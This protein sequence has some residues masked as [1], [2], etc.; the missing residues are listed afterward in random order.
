MFRAQ[1]G[2]Y[3]SQFYSNGP[4]LHKKEDENGV[5]YKAAFFAGSAHAG[6]VERIRVFDDII[7]KMQSNEQAFYDDMDVGNI[8]AFNKKYMLGQKLIEY[9]KARPGGIPASEIDGNFYQK[10]QYFIL[11]PLANILNIKL[12]EAQYREIIEDIFKKHPEFH[13]KILTMVL[14]EFNSTLSIREVQEK[15]K[16]A[17]WLVMQANF[18]SSRT[19]NKYF[20]YTGDFKAMEGTERLVRRVM[21]KNLENNRINPIIA[22]ELN[23]YYIKEFLKPDIGK[24]VADAKK[25][26]NEEIPK[27]IASSGIGKTENSRKKQ[28]NFYIKLLTATIDDWANNIEYQKLFKNTGVMTGAIGEFSFSVSLFMN[29]DQKFIIQNNNV[30]KKKIKLIT[31]SNVGEKRG[32]SPKASYNH[33][34]GLKEGK[35]RTPGQ[36]TQDIMFIGKS[37]RKYAFSVKNYLSVILEKAGGAVQIRGGKKIDTFM[38]DI[39]QSGTADS[40]SNI[41]I[42]EDEIKRFAYVLVNNLFRDESNDDLLNLFMGELINF[43][44]QNEFIKNL[45]HSS[46][47]IL[48]TY[49]DIRNSFLVMSGMYLIPMSVILTNI[50]DN[51][52]IALNKDYT[53]SKNNS[54]FNIPKFDLE[55]IVLPNADKLDTDK[56]NIQNANEYYDNGR[57]T[58][59]GAPQYGDE[60]LAYGIKAGDSIYD[61]LSMPDMEFRIDRLLGIIEAAMR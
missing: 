7:T 24:R 21:L 10:I 49:G 16:D 34:T 53:T 61:K 46:A 48:K 19:K 32:T 13:K 14:Q 1:L 29:P 17:L 12:E 51:L 41:S 59:P 20:R 33:K 8:T 58:W 44:L 35:D 9:A 11:V 60:M 23:N 22:E 57:Y 42:T 56:K 55:G 43:Y 40:I 6:R 2:D 37:R 30:L 45:T 25:L 39:L 47:E 52:Q 3:L 5:L 4:Y 54:L 50:R 28:S 38:G 36:I 27:I 26:L 31:K 18:L 15:A